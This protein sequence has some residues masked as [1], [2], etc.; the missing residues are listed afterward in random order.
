MYIFQFDQN[1]D[2]FV[3]GLDY[4]KLSSQIWTRDR[5]NVLSLL[6]FAL[7]VAYCSLPVAN[8][9]LQVAL[10]LN[11]AEKEHFCVTNY[12]KS[13]GLSMSHLFRDSKLR[14]GLYLSIYYG[15]SYICICMFALADQMTER[16]WVFATNSNFLIP[17]SF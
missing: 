9:G 13:R 6:P 10:C 3:S 17:I 14:S 2:F 5:E 1:K 12:L 8:C 7:P 15:Y 16:N 11:N 4:E